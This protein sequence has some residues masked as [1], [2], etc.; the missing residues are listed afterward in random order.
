MYDKIYN[1]LLNALDN[2]INGEYTV[3]E[4]KETENEY[5]PDNCKLAF[6]RERKFSKVKMKDKV[7]N[8]DVL[9]ACADIL[10]KLCPSATPTPDT[11]TGREY[12]VVILPETK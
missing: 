6:V 2:I 8:L 3:E 12:G 1:D 7:Y 11:D 5:D 10:L 4:I 9:K